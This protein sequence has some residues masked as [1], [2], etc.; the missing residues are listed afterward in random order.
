MPAVPE[1]EATWQTEFSIDHTVKYYG[2]T[3]GIQYWVQWYG[4]SSKHD[5]WGL[6]ENIPANFVTRYQQKRAQ[7]LAPT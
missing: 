2:A 4:Y 6:E 7:R 3:K 1:T 5:T